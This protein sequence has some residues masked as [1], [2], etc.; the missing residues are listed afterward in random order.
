ML[1]TWL[2]PDD[3]GR[4]MEAC[5]TAPGVGFHVAWAISDNTRRWWSLDEARSLG[6]RPEDDSEVFASTLPGDDPDVLRRVGGGFCS[7]SFDAPV[8][9]PAAD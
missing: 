9:G 7:P 5:L 8:P 1:S 3:A 2:S 4:L 6:Y